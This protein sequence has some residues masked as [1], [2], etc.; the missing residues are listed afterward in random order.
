MGWPICNQGVYILKDREL[1]RE[2]VT[3]S[4]EAGYQALC[5]TVDTPLAGN[6]E[7]DLVNGMVM[8]P[9]F[10]A[11]TLFSYATHFRW[12]FNLLRHPDFR[13]AN[14]AHRV[15]ALGSGA[16]GLIE[17]VNSQFDRT[18]TWDDAA[19]L[20]EQWDGPFVIKGST[21][22]RTGS[23]RASLSPAAVRRVT[24]PSA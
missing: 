15:D 11:K 4:R 18:V 1:T 17:Y 12:A 13:L 10:T 8:P 7:R 14:V 16:M 19:W 2:F 23:S 21:S 3:R 9:K 20:A 5:L 24:R 22:S 6:R